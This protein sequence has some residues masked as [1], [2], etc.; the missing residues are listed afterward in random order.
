MFQHLPAA[1]TEVGG[2][3]NHCGCCRWCAAVEQQPLLLLLPVARHPMQLLQIVRIYSPELALGTH[4]ILSPHF[5]AVEGG[6]GIC[7]CGQVAAH[8]LVLVVLEVALRDET[9]PSGQP[10]RHSSFT[11]GGAVSDGQAF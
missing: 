11:A 5:H 4:G 3:C 1:F 7:L 10:T 6:G 9:K 8:H 2:C